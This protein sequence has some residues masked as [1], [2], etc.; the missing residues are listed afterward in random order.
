M[1]P[2][3]LLQLYNVTEM[4]ARTGRHGDSILDILLSPTLELEN[5]ETPQN[6]KRKKRKILRENGLTR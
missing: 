1:K 4:F 6:V 2:V 5:H 3:N